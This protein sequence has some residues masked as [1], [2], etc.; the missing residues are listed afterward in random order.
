MWV[1]VGS[2]GIGYYYQLVLKEVVPIAPELLI[3][4][5]EKNFFFSVKYFF[6]ITFKFY[7]KRKLPLYTFDTFLKVSAPAKLR[8]QDRAS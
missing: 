4:I 6:S 2:I 5:P 3:K 1:V 7:V 8:G